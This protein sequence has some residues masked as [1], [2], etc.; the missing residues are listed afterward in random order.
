MIFF[1]VAQNSNFE[2]K[3]GPFKKKN[4]IRVKLV[5]TTVMKE[6]NSQ[7]VSNH[8]TLVV[9]KLTLRLSAIIPHY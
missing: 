7:I 1:P 2:K 3:I 9:K 4:L 8:T 6:V 5:T